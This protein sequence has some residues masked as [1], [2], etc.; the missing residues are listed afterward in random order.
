MPDFLTLLYDE[1]AD[2]LFSFL[3]SV[4]G[5]EGDARD[6]MQ[7]V[8]IKIARRPELLP[9]VRDERAFLL[10]LA[11]NSARDLFRRSSTRTSYETQFAAEAFSP[12]ACTENADARTFQDALTA[13]L[14]SLPAE[15]REVVHLKLW[16]GRTFDAIATILEISLNTTASRYRYGIDKLRDCLRPLHEELK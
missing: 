2:A 9:G 12:F 10:R 3:L 6:A 13:A 7:E 5:H 14:A 11:H 4:T 1:H 15:Q 8:F 16:E